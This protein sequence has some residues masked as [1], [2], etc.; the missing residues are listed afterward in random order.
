[1]LGQLVTLSFDLKHFETFLLYR[2]LYTHIM[3]VTWEY[4]IFLGI[5][6]MESKTFFNRLRRRFRVHLAL[7]V[8]PLVSLLCSVYAIYFAVNELKLTL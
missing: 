7:F 8:S 3:G 1:M 6:W 2:A 5:E 4:H